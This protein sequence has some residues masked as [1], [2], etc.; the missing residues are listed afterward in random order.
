LKSAVPHFRNLS[1]FGLKKLLNGV[2]TSTFDT[3]LKDLEER[4]GDFNKAQARSTVQKF[5]D[6]KGDVKTWSSE[7]NFDDLG[8]LR[9]GLTCQQTSSM[10]KVVFMNDSIA[11]G[12]RE[13]AM[14]GNLDADQRKGFVESKKSQKTPKSWGKS[15]LQQIKPMLSQVGNHDLKQMPDSTVRDSMKDLLGSQS[16]NDDQSQTLLEKFQSGTGRDLTKMTG[17]DM[18]DLGTL[19]SKLGTEQNKKLQDASFKKV[20]EYVGKFGSPRKGSTQSTA[21]RYFGDKLGKKSDGRPDTSKMKSMDLTKTP[22]LLAGL[23]KT[24]LKNISESE[25]RK[26]IDQTSA[27]VGNLDTHQAKI[28]VDKA[29]MNGSQSEQKQWSADQIRSWGDYM[30]GFKSKDVDQMDSKNVSNAVVKDGSQHTGLKNHVRN[31]LPSLQRKLTQKTQEGGERRPSKMGGDL[32]QHVSLRQMRKLNDSDTIYDKDTFKSSF[33]R[34]Q[35]SQMFDRLKRPD[36]L[37]APDSLDKDNLTKWTGQTIRDYV[38]G[39]LSGASSDDLEKLPIDS[40][41]DAISTL[42]QHGYTH[43]QGQTMVDSFRKQLMPNFTVFDTSDVRSL[44]PM[45]DQLYG[46]DLDEL[47]S[48]ANG[49][50]NMKQVV[51]QL[52]N[53]DLSQN[54][55]QKLKDL[56]K[57]GRDALSDDSDSQ[58]RRRSS[59]ELSADKVDRLGNLMG[60]IEPKD[61]SSITDEALQTKMRDFS[62]HFNADQSSALADHVLSRLG[63]GNPASL[64]GDHLSDMGRAIHNL[65]DDNLKA[66]DSSAVGD[67]MDDLRD[68]NWTRSQAKIMLGHAEKH[69]NKSVSQWNGDHFRRVKNMNAGHDPDVIRN[70]SAEALEDTLGSF[71]GERMDEDQ[72]SALR[73]AVKQKLGDNSEAGVSEDHLTELG[74]IANGD[75]KFLGGNTRFADSERSVDVLGHNG[76]QA[77]DKETAQAGFRTIKQKLSSRQGSNKFDSVGISNMGEFITGASASDVNAMDAKDVAD[78]LPRL[79]QNH[80]QNMDTNAFDSLR[81]KASRGMSDDGKTEK[82][83]SQWSAAEAG[84]RGTLVGPDDT[85]HYQPKHMQALSSHTYTNMKADATK[86]IPADSYRE[87]GGDNARTMQ[88]RPDFSQLGLSQEQTEAISAAATQDSLLAP[89]ATV[90]PGT[91][92]PSSRPS[93]SSRVEAAFL[94]V[95]LLVVFKGFL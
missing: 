6:S 45:V 80:Y 40:I 17:D 9:K 47:K 19:K 66:L 71:P 15:D 81:Q 68:R 53:K 14:K 62:K 86:A 72:K 61:V 64:T 39:L 21:S 60:G 83:A 29:K 4:S 36:S 51:C 23:S 49:L 92:P 55:P 94:L 1:E 44:G 73:A 77:M 87:M 26:S 67:A 75:K 10:Q 65:S 57:R 20:A 31:A 79:G 28:L 43:K 27:F 11:K 58:R 37:G 74:P 48:G 89:E 35:V 30:S 25:I 93:S 41:P 82:P 56:F 85:K 70:M 91:A 76:G 50:E 46:K 33:K 59:D 8:G 52:R 13:D 84:E 69:F 32:S 22:K 78:A 3:T 2:N 54:S 90:S 38:G 34:H 95:S 12:F 63:K 16:W 5:V 88:Q 24:Q 42:G 7:D 18:D